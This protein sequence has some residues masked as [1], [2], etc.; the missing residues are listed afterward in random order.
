MDGRA[1]Y[2]FAVKTGPVVLKAVA[3]K[4][5][6]ALNDVRHFVLHQANINI[7]RKIAESLGMPMERFVVNLDRYGNTAAA[8]VLIALDQIVSGGVVKPGDII[9]VAAFGGGLSWGGTIIRF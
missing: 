1:V 9:A 2:D 3:D 8:S 6:I 5:G 7:L 4:A